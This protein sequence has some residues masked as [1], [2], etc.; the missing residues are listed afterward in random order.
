MCR[1]E[2]R[3][4]LTGKIQQ[5]V[6]MQLLCLSA[7]Q[8]LRLPLVLPLPDTQLSYRIRRIPLCGRGGLDAALHTQQLRRVLG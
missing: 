5:R 2:V 4:F 6:S 8:A 1:L 3:A 7:I